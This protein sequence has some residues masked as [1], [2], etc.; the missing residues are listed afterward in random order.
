MN[1]L[2]CKNASGIFLLPYYPDLNP[3]EN[4]FSC[5]KSKLHSIRPRSENRGNLQKNIET[6]IISLGNLTEYYRKFSETIHAINN[7]Q[8]E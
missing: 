5:T 3:I 6:V 1:Y 2:Y 7:K 4:V 8:M